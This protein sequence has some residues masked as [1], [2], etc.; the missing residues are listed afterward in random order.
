MPDR[1][2]HTFVTYFRSIFASSRSNAELSFPQQTSLP[3]EDY[4]YSI[5]NKEEIFVV[6]KGMK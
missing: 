4:S 6:L 5:S 2:A 1:I 3:T